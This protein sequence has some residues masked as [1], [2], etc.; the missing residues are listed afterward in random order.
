VKRRPEAPPS[1]RA[2]IVA[3]EYPH[4]AWRAAGD[5]LFAFTRVPPSQ[6]KSAQDNG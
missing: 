5:A 2:S 4:E 3:L 1:R 6:W